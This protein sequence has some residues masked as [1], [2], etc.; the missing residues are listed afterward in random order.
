MAITGE[1][2]VQRRAEHLTTRVNGSVLPPSEWRTSSCAAAVGERG[3][4][5]REGGEDGWRIAL[6]RGAGRPDGGGEI[7]PVRRR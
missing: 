7:A 4:M 3:A 1:I 2:D 5:K 6:S